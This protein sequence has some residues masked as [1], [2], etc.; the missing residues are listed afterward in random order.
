MFSTAGASRA[1]LKWRSRNVR[2]SLSWC[3]VVLVTLMPTLAIPLPALATE[4]LTPPDPQPTAGCDWYGSVSF[5]ER[6]Y[7]YS[8]NALASLSLFRSL[9]FSSSAASGTPC[10]ASW[11]AAV[12]Q[13]TTESGA[14]STADRG[15]G[16]GI[17]AYLRF[18][19]NPFPATGLPYAYADTLA[20]T[21]Y[22]IISSYSCPDGSTGSSTR[23]TAR[24]ARV[25]RLQ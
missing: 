22:P 7:Q 15:S 4:P 20:S 24:V 17:D 11:S 18:S 3:A 8:E 19:L 16:T 12:E 2:S 14:C 23:L 25:F 6:S 1:S 13:T 9:T 5:T 10:G 21:E